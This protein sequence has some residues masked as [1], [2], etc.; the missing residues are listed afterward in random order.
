MALARRRWGL[1]DAMGRER[2]GFAPKKQV[3]HDPFVAGAGG[4]AVR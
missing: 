2:H 1:P 3:V 4:S